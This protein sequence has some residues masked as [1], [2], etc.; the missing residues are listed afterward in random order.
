M[1]FLNINL[2]PNIRLSLELITIYFVVPSIALFPVHLAIKITVIIVAFFYILRIIINKKDLIPKSHYGYK[3]VEKWFSIL[4]PFLLF[5]LIS[6]AWVLI[7][8]KEYL[9]LAP[10]KTP[11]LWFFLWFVYSA[12][13]VYPQELV[14]RAFFIHRYGSILGEKTLLWV[15]A[16]AFCYG[17][18]V[19]H[20]AF[21]YVLTFLGA[22]IFMNIYQKNHSLLLVS[23]VHS[24]YGFWIFTVGMGDYFAFPM[25]QP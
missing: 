2:L 17:H 25:P 13:S 18:V 19:I 11:G 9:F 24:S 8:R 10:Q 20:N 4:C 12:F 7:F 1:T 23:L 21:A 3:R 22:F 14:Y 15:G 6:I 5:I 16:L